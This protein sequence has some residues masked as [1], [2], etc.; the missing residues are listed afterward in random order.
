MY[1]KEEKSYWLGHCLR[2]T[3]LLTEGRKNG[4]T[5]GRKRFLIIFE[6]EKNKKY[7]EKKR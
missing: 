5:R 2:K 6:I 4:M 7:V 1:L 3:C